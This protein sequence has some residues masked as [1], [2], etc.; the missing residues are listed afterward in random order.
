MCWP[1]ILRLADRLDEKHDQS[2]R[3]VQVERSDG[4]LVIRA[5]G[6]RELTRPAEHIA[7]ARHLLETVCGMAVLLRPLN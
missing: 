7:A 1:G 2:I 4:F 3:R 6:Y 5:E